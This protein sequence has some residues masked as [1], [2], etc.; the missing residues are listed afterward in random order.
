MSNLPDSLAWMTNDSI[1]KLTWDDILKPNGVADQSFGVVTPDP[2]E[3]PKHDAY[4]GILEGGAL[5]VSLIF[6]YVF[7]SENK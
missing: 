2:R 7:F 1:P 4:L 6:V 3:T 5:L